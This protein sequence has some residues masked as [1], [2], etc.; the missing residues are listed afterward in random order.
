MVTVYDTDGTP[1]EV[2]D[3]SAF[4]AGSVEPP[5]HPGPGEPGGPVVPTAAQLAVAATRV[6]PGSPGSRW[7][8]LSR[9]W[10]VV[11]TP[12]SGKFE[13][14]ERQGPEGL[15]P[16]NPTPGA[17]TLV[18]MRG[19]A[20]P[21][22]TPTQRPGPPMANADPKGALHAPALATAT[23]GMGKGGP[24]LNPEAP[25]TAGKVFVRRG[26]SIPAKT[27]IFPNPRK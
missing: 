23:P 7:D 10:V 9:T 15:A 17:P 3:P 14:V 5:H 13:G 27:R 16:A 2:D 8:P 6:R 4:V 11:T 25:P 12:P 20:S 1:H 21:L 19:D 18:P 22:P 24:V 26:Y